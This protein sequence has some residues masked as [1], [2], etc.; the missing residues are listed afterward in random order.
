MLTNVFAALSMIL[1]VLMAFRCRGDFE[2]FLIAIQVEDRDFWESIGRPVGLEWRGT[3]FEAVVGRA[4]LVVFSRVD[5]S[6]ALKTCARRLVLS[7]LLFVF[8]L[9]V[10]PMTVFSLG[11]VNA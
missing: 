9:L 8:F 3:S 1:G 4:Q 10:L 7:L 5:S 2:R 11:Y 6:G